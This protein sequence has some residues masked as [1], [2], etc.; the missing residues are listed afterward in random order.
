MLSGIQKKSNHIKCCEA[1]EVTGFSVC[2]ACAIQVYSSP[3]CSLVSPGSDICTALIHSWA[4]ILG[5]VAGLEFPGQ[6]H[7]F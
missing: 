6:H 4:V 7:A 3:A 1:N 5:P 2:V